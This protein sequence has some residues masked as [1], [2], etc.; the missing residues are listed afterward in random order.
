MKREIIDE[1]KSRWVSKWELCDLL[2]CNSREVRAAMERLN[3]EL[4]EKGSCL[5]ST[6]AKKGYHIPDP[7]NE[8]DMK[9][10]RGAVKELKSKAI[11]LLAKRKAIYTF[12][13]INSNSGPTLFD[14]PTE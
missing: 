11:A 1:L 2:D 7:T 8:E 9:L 4:A 3:Q 10:A 14:E 5:L 13:S 12:V 6:S